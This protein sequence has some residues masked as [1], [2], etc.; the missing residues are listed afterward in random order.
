MILNYLLPRSNSLTMGSFR[1]TTPVAFF[2]AFLNNTP[3]VAMMT[4]AV[5]D[6]SKRIGRSP[7]RFLIPLSFASIL[8]SSTTLIGTSVNLTVAGLIDEAQMAPLGFFELAGVGVPMA[9]AGLV[10]LIFVVPRVLPDRIDP[11]EAFGE[12]RREYLIAMRVEPEC[13]LVGQSVEAAG[14]RNLPGLFLVEIERRDRI[15]TPSLRTSR[16]ARTTSSSSPA[17]SRRSSICSA[18]AASCLRLRRCR[19]A[20]RTPP[21]RGRRL[22]FV[23]ARRTQREDVELPH[24]LRRRHHRRAPQRRTRGREDRPHR[25]ARG[26]HPAHADD[27]GLGRRSIG[28]APISIS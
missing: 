23:A 22:E 26:R 12:R 20:D 2:S 18:S 27:S 14:L 3:I 15:I 6:W 21:G 19:C 1:I 7:S 8:G 9:L 24:H 10:Y 25:P 28:T 4:P 13:P 11:S 17:S 16:S 5:I